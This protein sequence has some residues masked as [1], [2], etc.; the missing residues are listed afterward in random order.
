MNVVKWFDLRGLDLGTFA[1]LMNR[2]SGIGLTLYL[3]LHLLVLSTLARGAQA[4]DQFIALVKNPI[5]LF[6]EYLVVVAV[7]VHGLNGLRIA[8]TSLGVV[9]PWQ[10]QLFIGLMVVAIGG[11][12]IFAVRM[13]GG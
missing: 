11:C 4:Y 3:F 2:I 1:F 12:A 8:L 5:F 13:L 9:V 7:L 10:K 6:G